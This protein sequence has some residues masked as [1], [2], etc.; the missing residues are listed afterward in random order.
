MI[1][2]EYIYTLNKNQT[3][4]F[5]E[6]S[7]YC[8]SIEYHYVVCRIVKTLKI[9]FE[10]FVWTSFV[11]I[12][13]LFQMYCLFLYFMLFYLCFRILIFVSYGFF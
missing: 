4:F 9:R 13:Y 10:S 1:I 7:T 5:K 2:I 8:F 11:F 3:Q 12:F 6:E